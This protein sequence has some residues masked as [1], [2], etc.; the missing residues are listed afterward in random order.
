MAE[1]SNGLGGVIIGTDC[2]IGCSRRRYHAGLPFYTRL[3]CEGKNSKIIIGNRCRLNGVSIHAESEIV[4]GNNCVMASGISIMD[5]NGHVVCSMD[6][7]TGRDMPKPIRIG[8]NVWIGLNAII[9]KGTVIGDNC[10]ISA[11]SIVKGVFP[12]NSVIAGNPAV[13][14]KSIKLTE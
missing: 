12:E 3:L 4:I 2:K 10:V 7:T 13:V 6:R 14:V 8:N 1:F 5:S 9:L 11:G